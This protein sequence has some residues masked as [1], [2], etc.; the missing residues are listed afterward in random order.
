VPSDDNGLA[1]RVACDPLTIRQASSLL[2]VPV[3][4]LRSWERRYDIPRTARTTGGHRRY[5]RTAID[6]LRLMRDE[7]ARGKRAGQAAV[8]ARLLLEPP[9]PARALVEAFLVAAQAMDP[10]H[11][12][13]CL[14]AA[15]EQLGLDAALDEVMMPAMRRLGR[16][17]EV[18]RCDV[19][20]EHLA[21]EAVRTWLG[22]I[23][24]FAPQPQHPGPVVLACGPHDTHTLG[25][26]A[27]TA[28][29]VRDG[30][31]CRLLGARTPVTALVTT[32]RTVDAAAVV[33]VSH[34]SV[35]RRSAGDAIRAAAELGVPVFYAGNAFVALPTRRLPAV[36]LGD[37]LSAA[38]RTVDAALRV[39]RARPA[40]DHR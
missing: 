34:L 7:I 27:L 5:G 37:S 13:S 2:A 39:P 8:S 19:G 36:Y 21:T 11:V 33:V 14:D 6:E 35:G 20:H 4:T 12:R 10:A 40:A 22:R 17:W 29:L 30:R 38:A 32:A 16:R 18:G 23:I 1:G 25:L 15:A 28:L 9:E 24:A 31:R 3:S 26:E